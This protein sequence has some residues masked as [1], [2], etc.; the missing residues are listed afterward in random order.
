MAL[1]I[2]KPNT[3]VFCVD[4]WLEMSPRNV[5]AATLMGVAR[6]RGLGAQK[7]AAPLRSNSAAKQ[8]L[9]RLERRTKSI[10]LANSSWRVTHMWGVC[11]LPEICSRTANFSPV[12]LHNVYQNAT[13]DMRHILFITRQCKQNASVP[14]R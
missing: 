11:I 1:A 2:A 6:R 3:H 8:S 4:L 13:S 12:L 14:N 5:C 10:K 7:R 9:L